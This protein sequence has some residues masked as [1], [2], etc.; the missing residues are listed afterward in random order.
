MEVNFAQEG[1]T[2]YRFTRRDQA[3]VELQLEIARR[4]RIGIS[5]GFLRWNRGETHNTCAHSVITCGQRSD[6]KE[7]I[8]HTIFAIFHTLM[9]AYHRVF[10]VKNIHKSV[11]I[12]HASPTRT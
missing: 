10:C 2:W 9:G 3:A 5:R 12:A 6:P 8:F 1:A 11:C 4:T 7:A